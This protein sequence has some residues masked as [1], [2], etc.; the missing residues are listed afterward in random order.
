MTPATESTNARARAR[1]GGVPRAGHPILRSC[2]YP[3]AGYPQSGSL[4]LFMAV[5]DTCFRMSDTH[6]SATWE[7]KMGGQGQ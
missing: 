3:R 5:S 1:V 4:S 6:V 7:R 2:L